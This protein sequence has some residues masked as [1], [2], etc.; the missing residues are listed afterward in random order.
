MWNQ[1]HTRP[2]VIQDQLAEI[3]AQQ[4]DN[5][6]LWFDFSQDVRDAATSAVSDPQAVTLTRD[7]MDQAVVDSFNQ[8]ALKTLAEGSS[9]DFWMRDDLLLIGN[10]QPKPYVEF[11]KNGGNK[12][13]L[14]MKA[15]GGA[16]SSD[17]VVVKQEAWLDLA[18]LKE[19]IRRFSQK[20]V[21]VGDDS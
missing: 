20:K 4:L 11:A 21:T 10:N 19:A 12:G 17:E 2:Y 5:D 18:A 3:A 13:T 14:K 16:F 9:I 8:D 7:R 15:K 6:D 1:R